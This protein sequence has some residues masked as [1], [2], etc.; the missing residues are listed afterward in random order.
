M[1]RPVP[2][3]RRPPRRQF[4]ARAAAATSAL[5]LA[6]CD[7]L[8]RTQWFPKVLDSVEPLNEAVAKLVARN[9]LA[10]EFAETDRSPSFRSNGSDDPGTDQYN[11]WVRSE[12]A[13]YALVVGGLCDAPRSFSLADLRALP[14]RTQITRHDCVEGWSAIAKWKGARLRALLDVVKPRDE[15]RYV[16]FY[17]ADPMARDG[18]DLYYESIDFDDARHEQTILAYELND[19]ALPVANGA[20]IRLRVER[21]LGYKHAK[22]I[23]SIEFVA[24]FAHIAGGKGGYWEDQGYQ[25]FAGI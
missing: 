21:Q 17:C 8:S 6:G 18:T 23:T 4:L 2:L 14:S 3:R 16:V 1:N 22:Y 15:A 24:T 10:Q 11:A 25:W 7:N 20:P 19:A 9:A 5:A 12:F 13:D